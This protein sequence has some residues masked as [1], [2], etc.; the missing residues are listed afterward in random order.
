MANKVNSYLEA[1]P[2]ELFKKCTVDHLHPQDILRLSECSKTLHG[3]CSGDLV[4]TIAVT[5][6][7]S[8]TQ[9]LK[10]GM[11]VANSLIE[12]ARVFDWALVGERFRL[13]GE[14]MAN[15]PT[16]LWKTTK[17]LWLPNVEDE[18]LELPVPESD[19]KLS[20]GLH[21]VHTPD[22]QKV[23]T[24]IEYLRLTRTVD[25]QRRYDAVF[26]VHPS[27]GKTAGVAIKASQCSTEEW[28]RKWM[29][30][31]PLDISS[32][33][34]YHELAAFVAIVYGTLWQFNGHRHVRLV[35]NVHVGCHYFTANI[36]FS[37]AC[38]RRLWEDAESV[39]ADAFLDLPALRA[40]RPFDDGVIWDGVVDTVREFVGESV[41][42]T[43]A[44]TFGGFVVREDDA[45]VFRTTRMVGVRVR[46]YT[47]GAHG[48]TLE[49]DDR[50][51]AFEIIGHVDLL[52]CASLFL[53]M[54]ACVWRLSPG[55]M[56]SSTMRVAGEGARVTDAA[57][58]RVWK[59]AC[60]YLQTKRRELRQMLN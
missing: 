30:L 44:E 37:A 18:V 49:R 51:D 34:E 41:D 15:N 42:N 32:V 5:E 48:V 40:A 46:V 13:L 1:L 14:A 17:N 24:A 59:L 23:V 11:A 29:Y 47:G 54:A 6:A 52:R 22:N 26:R 38:I 36:K 3:N 10:Q 58:C 8:V 28:R 55:R 2:E 7:R 57:V 27:T 31:L 16:M 60:E 21:F 4:P 53:V 39:A 19:L 20:I 25:N 9:A 50:V 33:A 43:L 35:G 45:V 12:Q 56:P